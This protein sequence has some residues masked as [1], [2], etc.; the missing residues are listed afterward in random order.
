MPTRL[1]RVFAL[2]LQAGRDARARGG[3]SLTRHWKAGGISPGSVLWLCLSR[4]FKEGERRI[5]IAATCWDL[6]IVPTTL[7][8]IYPGATH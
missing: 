8:F 3:D 4:A 5:K 6:L 2:A 7:V 1:G